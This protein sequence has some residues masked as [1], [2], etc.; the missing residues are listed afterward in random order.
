LG[1]GLL[2]LVRRVDDTRFDDRVQSAFDQAPDIERWAR[3][4]LGENHAPHGSWTRSAEATLH[5]SAV[6]IALACVADPDPYLLAA[7]EGAIEAGERRMLAPQL[8]EG[9]TLVAS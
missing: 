1:V 8:T 2:T 6:G 3:R 9:R 4:Y 5:T 7:L